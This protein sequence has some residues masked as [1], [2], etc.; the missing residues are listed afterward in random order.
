M[1][2]VF[3]I[4][5]ASMCTTA[6]NTKQITEGEDAYSMLPPFDNTG[7]NVF[8]YPWPFRLS[9]S[10]KSTTERENAEE[11]SEAIQSRDFKKADELNQE[12]T[13]N[14]GYFDDWVIPY[15]FTELGRMK[16]MKREKGRS[17]NIR[18]VRRR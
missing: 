9:R 15:H 13:R 17:F 8:A 7:R 10:V 1:S 18:L 6:A 11:E 2:F 5:A 16:D 4:A 3:L 14:T 12:D